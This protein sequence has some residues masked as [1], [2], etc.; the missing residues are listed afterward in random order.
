MKPLR[1]LTV[2]FILAATTAHAEDLP[3]RFILLYSH[4]VQGELEPCGCSKSPVG[5]F[6][7]RAA[8]IKEAREK[9]GDAPVLVLDAG[10]FFFNEAEKNEYS[11]D[12]IAMRASHML[13]LYSM[14]GYDALGLG[15]YDLLEGASMLGYLSGRCRAPIFSSNLRLE[16]NI[17][18][19]HVGADGIAYSH[20]DG[21]GQT[22]PMLP[23]SK[24]GVSFNLVSLTD[25]YPRS[26][27]ASGFLLDPPLE[28]WKK[29]RDQALNSKAFVIVMTSLSDEAAIE[30]ARDLGKNGI[31]IRR[32][33]PMP[34]TEVPPN[35]LSTL[36]LRGQALGRADVLLD[37]EGDWAEI[38]ASTLLLDEQILPDEAVV[39]L[40]QEYNARLKDVEV[41]QFAEAPPYVRRYAGVQ[42]CGECHEPQMAW[43]T[44]TPHAHAMATLEKSQNHYNPDCISCH[45]TGYG[46]YYGFKRQDTQPD[47]SNVQCESCHG[48]ESSMMHGVF[49]QSEW[50]QEMAPPEGYSEAQW[51]ALGP[52]L[53]Q[54]KKSDNRKALMAGLKATCE[55]CHTPEHSENFEFQ[56]YLARMKCPLGLPEI[57]IIPDPPAEKPASP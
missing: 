30:V 51:K 50:E 46:E 15:G 11:D 25:T 57:K 23:M 18:H 22:E 9:A 13:Q 54:R 35:L 52:K 16:S 34:E 3:K 43:W 53:R 44:A 45:V 21:S 10:N 33:Q 2:L 49:T 27:L 36:S 40:R 19:T 39:K 20:N 4:D 56:S 17:E 6:A 47:L 28:A 37:D 5:G 8:A 41:F 12:F 55:S 7:R 14:L 29:V 48:I 31:V 26:R 24:G 38:K 42:K 32:T 1:A